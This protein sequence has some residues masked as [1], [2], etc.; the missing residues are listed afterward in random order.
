MKSAPNPNL[1]I[2]YGASFASAAALA[3]NTPTQIVAPASNLRGVVV[4]AATLIT[5]SGAGTS[6]LT[7]IAKSS[8]PT[9][10]TDGD[11]Y[12]AATAPA[13]GQSGA[14]FFLPRPVF[15][16]AGKGLYVISNNIETGNVKSVLY[17]VL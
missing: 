7:L 8:A 11:V 2:R 16:P 6:I 10:T 15:V 12:G 4:H 13:A 5:S 3:A 9:G 1:P 17:T 14:P